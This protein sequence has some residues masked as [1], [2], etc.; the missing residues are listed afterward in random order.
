MN[1]NNEIIDRLGYYT[2][3][4]IRFN[5][6][7]DALIYGTAHKKQ[8][9]W[10]FNDRVFGQVPWEVEPA[11][12]LSELYKRRALQLREKYDYLV[13]NYSGG[14]DSQNILDTFINNN[15]KLDE[16]IC[17]WSVAGETGLYQPS[18]VSRAANFHSEWDLTL[19]PAMEKISKEHP[20]IK[21]QFYDYTAD[22]TKFFNDDDPWYNMLNGAQF[23]PSHI[24]RYAIGLDRYQDM[25]V[26]RGM[27]GCQ[28]FGVDKPRI[29][30]DDNT[31]YTY[32]LD[33]IGGTA[34]HLL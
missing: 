4:G 15:I 10:I 7:V 9:N 3:D 34:R 1:I 12:S 27:R 13:L 25:F 5:N 16:I 11:E 21:I 8:V 28:I 32:F 33:I 2:V 18:T 20:E 31:F 29:M 26:E 14:A 22:A 6:K 19:K 17:R 23:G 24:S 30:F